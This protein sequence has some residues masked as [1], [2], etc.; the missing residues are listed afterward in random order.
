MTSSGE[1]E[2]LATDGKT[3][4]VTVMGPARVSLT[5]DFGTGTAQVQAITPEGA[6]IDLTLGSF[7]A[8]TDTL[9]DF[10][11]RSETDLRVKLSGST[12]PALLVWIQGNAP[13][14]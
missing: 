9:F 13:H 1:I 14:H 6:E 3:K 7:T 8:A 10:P 12:N 4:V 2:T 5:G 11:E